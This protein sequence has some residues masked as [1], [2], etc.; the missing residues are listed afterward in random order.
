[1]NNDVSHPQIPSNP[2]IA[3]S[4]GNNVGHRDTLNRVA[5]VLELLT[6][7]NLSDELSSGAENGLYW[8]QLMLI[9]SVRY[10]S[11]ALDN[12]IVGD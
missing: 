8:V 2:L 1:M 3:V 5:T 4:I 9:D 12:K 6:E 10:V 11:D 7:V